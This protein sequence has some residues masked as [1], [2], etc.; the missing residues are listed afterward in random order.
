M[1]SR[2]PPRKNQYA[3]RNT[4][5]VLKNFQETIPEE[6]PPPLERKPE[7]VD[8][9]STMY[10]KEL[11]EDWAQKNLVTR[12]FENKK[13]TAE[14]D[15]SKWRNNYTN[16]IEKHNRLTSGELLSNDRRAVGFVSSLPRGVHRELMG[17]TTGLGGNSAVGR[18]GNSG[19]GGS[20]GWGGGRC[21]NL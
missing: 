13:K 5:H 9:E 1:P 11:T 21:L 18:G 12:T 8:P 20:T 10:I 19:F 16:N 17:G 4:T 7:S 6:T 3:P 2:P 14:Q 15:Y